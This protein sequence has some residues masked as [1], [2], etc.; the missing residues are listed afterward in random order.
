VS[1]FPTPHHP[2]TTD[3]SPPENIH[4]TPITSIVNLRPIPHHLDAASEQD[5]LARPLPG[6][7]AAT[8]AAAKK[9]AANAIQMTLKGAMDD[10]GVA[11]ETMADRLRA[12]QAETWRTME[13]Y[14]DETE[15]AWQ[16]YNECLFLSSG[17]A[18]PDDKGKGKAVDAAPP[19]DSGLPE[20]REKVARLETKWREDELLRGISGIKR[21]DRKPGE[22]A[23]Q[24]AAAEE[25][26][27]VVKKEVKAPEQA[28]V[29]KR[30]PGR[31][32]KPA[33]TAAATRGARTRPGTRGGGSG[34][35]DAMQVD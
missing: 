16:S 17:D 12:V 23:T 19:P 13:W 20:L 35:S 24:A 33:A 11:T 27:P 8:A 7:A 25:V 15:G 30:R 21:H 32:A 2:H 4:L 10:E 28:E 6:G 5:K 29:A 26:V 9:N 22:E 1:T 3:P 18:D 34:P 14:H 31:P